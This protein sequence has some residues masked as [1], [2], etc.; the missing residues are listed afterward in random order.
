VSDSTIKDKKDGKEEK[1]ESDGEEKKDGKNKE[2]GEKEYDG[3][4]LSGVS[5]L[6]FTWDPR[7]ESGKRVT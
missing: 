1:E 3:K 7:L 4:F 5:G 6:D 2:D